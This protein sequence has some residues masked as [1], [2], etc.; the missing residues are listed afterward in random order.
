MRGRAQQ[1]GRLATASV[2]VPFPFFIRSF[3]LSLVIA[4][5]DPAIHRAAQH[6]PPGQAR[7]RR[8]KSSEAKS[9]KRNEGPTPSF[10][11]RFTFA[12][13]TVALVTK[14]SRPD[15]ARERWSHRE[16]ALFRSS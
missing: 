13:I 1:H 4:G 8:G 3:L 6:G 14:D 12:F 9:A 7:W 10:Q 5:L 2:G 11:M 16:N 15:V